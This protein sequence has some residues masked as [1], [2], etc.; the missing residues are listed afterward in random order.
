MLLIG[1]I[2]KLLFFIRQAKETDLLVKVFYPS[3]PDGSRV[4]KYMDRTQ[5]NIIELIRTSA[6][7]LVKAAKT[8]SLTERA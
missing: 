4:P 8:R 3:M 7:I 1:Q 6:P 5:D 2:W